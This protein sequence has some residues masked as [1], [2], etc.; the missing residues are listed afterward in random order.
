MMSRTVWLNLSVIVPAFDIELGASQ[1]YGR[2]PRFRDVPYITLSK[3]FQ[4]DTL[5]DQSFLDELG[6]LEFSREG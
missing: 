3:T 5:V 6:G 4:V 2:L 1:L